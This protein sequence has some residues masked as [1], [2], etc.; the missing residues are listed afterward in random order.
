MDGIAPRFDGSG[1][2]TGI[3]LTSSGIYG[4]GKKITLTFQFTEKVKVTGTPQLAFTINAVIKSADYKSGSDTNTL[5]FE[6]TVVAGDSGQGI[7]VPADS[8]TLNGGTIKDFVGN[9]AVLTHRKSVN[10]AEQKVDTTAPT[11]SS[12]AMSS[13]AQTYGVGDKIQATVTFSEIW[14]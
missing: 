4:V 6:Y 5:T 10:W 3:H 2:S 14:Q 1:S 8:L 9:T 12:V 13:T 7:L 11:V